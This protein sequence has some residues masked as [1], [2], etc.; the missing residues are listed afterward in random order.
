GNIDVTANFAINTY[1]LDYVAGTNGSITGTA[2]QTVNYNANGT[3]VEAIPNTGYHFV[4]WSD[5]ST[6]NPR[7]DLNVT[8]NISVT[9]NF[10][11]NTYTLDYAAGTN[12]SITGTANQTVNYN[13]NG[14]AVTAVPNTGYHF[15]DWSD[16]STTNPRTDLNV[17]G[18]IDV[19]ANFAINT[20]LISA[21]VS[22]VST[23]TI[24]GD[25]NYNY[26][27]NVSLIAT[28]NTGY[29]FV[30]WTESGTQVST[31]ATFAFTA[32]ADRTLVA[33]FELSTGIETSIQSNSI[34]VYPNPVIDFVNLKLD[35]FNS[36]KLTY[37]LF[38]LNGKQILNKKIESSE[39]KIS[40]HSLV[41]ATYVLKV[42]DRNKELQSFKIIKD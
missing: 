21:S 29:T 26:G 17:T 41:P 40:M 23:G 39:T 10:A 6:T 4:N 35:N 13:A 19:T 5:A 2:S 33:N 28:P 14:T 11:I 3:S 37:Q 36:D 32:S 1:T 18:N 12:G 30:N 16:A 25:G 31:N 38:D 7:T 24:T 34:S 22:P 27:D 15:V 9:A 42:L 8:A 20:Y